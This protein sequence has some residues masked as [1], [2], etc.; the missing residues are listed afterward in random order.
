MSEATS[1][2]SEADKAL[3]ALI[4][5][6]IVVCHSVRVPSSIAATALWKAVAL[7][8]PDTKVS[9][10]VTVTVAVAVIAELTV[11]VA[12]IVAVPA[13]S[14]VTVPSSET[15]ATDGFDEVQ[16]TSALAVAGMIDTASFAPV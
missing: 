11:L 9:S 3:Y 6:L 10:S 2:L 4:A 7:V 14:A 12:V 13:L 8:L 16:L 15:V 5:A 1:V